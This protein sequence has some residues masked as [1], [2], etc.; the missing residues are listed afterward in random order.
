MYSIRC[1]C[2]VNYGI[3]I[4]LFGLPELHVFHL[5]MKILYLWRSIC[6]RDTSDKSKSPEILLIRID[7]RYIV[8]L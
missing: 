2:Q 1:F 4:G 8:V 6:N 7:E 5:S 3:S